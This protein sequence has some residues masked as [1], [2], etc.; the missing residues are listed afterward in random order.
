MAFIN[1]FK[2]PQVQPILEAEEG[3][4][5]INF[6]QPIPEK[7]ESDKVRLVPFVPSI[8]AKPFHATYSKYQADVERYLPVTWKTYSDLLTFSEYMVRQDPASCLFVVID[9][10]KPNDGENLEESIAGV[11]GYIHS[12]PSN[13]AVEL[14]PVV[15]LPPWQRTFMSSHAIGLALNYALNLPSE[16]GLG[17]RRVAWLANPFNVGSVRAAERMGFKAEGIQRWTWILP[18]GREGG[19]P[20]VDGKRG[21]NQGRDSA[22]LAICWDDWENGGREHVVKMM[23]RA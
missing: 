9:R 7:L 16:G 13:R 6:N 3:P 20:A 21:S 14:G 11:I 15:I 23:N 22:F 4:Y 5:D 18:D 1:N 17:L 8:H 2:P 10:T 19:K 12:S